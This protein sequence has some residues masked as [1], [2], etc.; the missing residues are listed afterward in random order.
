MKKTASTKAIA[1][2]RET[3]E[4]IDEAIAIQERRANDKEAF[5][6]RVGREHGPLLQSMR[7]YLL[8]KDPEK[9]GLEII[10]VAQSLR[11]FQ[12]QT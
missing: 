12:D 6:G 8:D 11:R 4:A 2:Y 5:Y 3:M 9:T 7:A 10:R 1:A